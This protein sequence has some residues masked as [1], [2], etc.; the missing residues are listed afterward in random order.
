M[1]DHIL[2]GT[3]NLDGE[4]ASLAATLGVTPSYGGRHEGLG[5]AN[6]LYSLGSGAYLEIIGPDSTRPAPE[7]GRILG[8]D[9]MMSSGVITWCARVP[10]LDDAVAHANALGFPYPEPAAMRRASAEG[11]LSW[12][13]AFNDFENPGGLAPLLIAW[14]EGVPHPST[15]AA[16]GLR[17]VSMHGQHPAPSRITALLS[18]LGLDLEVRRGPQAGLTVRIAS[19]GGTVPLRVASFL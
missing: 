7:G 17:L 9:H 3:Q 16:P 4:V 8:L 11:E 12:R 13:L 6:H 18:A 14:D 19:P 1:I 2:Y 15:S 10:D 5:T